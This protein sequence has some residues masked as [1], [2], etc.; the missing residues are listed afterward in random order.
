MDTPFGPLRNTSR[1]ANLGGADCSIF[2]LSLCI[3]L[4]CKLLLESLVA[5]TCCDPNR[6]TRCPAHSVLRGL[7]KTL[8]ESCKE[9]PLSSQISPSHPPSFPCFLKRA[10]K[11]P[12]KTRILYPYQTLRGP[13]WGLFFVPACPPLTAINGY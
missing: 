13:N 5:H 1:V 2:N 9:T 4:F 10:G 3:W 8:A 6:A 11:P 12:K 7:K